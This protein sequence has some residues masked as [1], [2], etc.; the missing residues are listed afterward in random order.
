MW[1]TQMMRRWMPCWAK[2]H[3]TSLTSWRMRT[4]LKPLPR[5]H[6][7]GKAR[8]S[9]RSSQEGRSDGGSPNSLQFK[10]SGDISFDQKA[11]DQRKAAVSFIKGVTQCT[12]CGQCGH[13]TGG[14]ECSKTPKDKGHGKNQ[15]GLP[16]RLARSLIPRSH[17]ETTLSSMRSLNPMTKR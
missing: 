16:R 5:L 7:T 10:A 11:K 6:S 17:R 4:L 8:V 13:W 9:R 12:A 2:C 1:P 15:K 3:L 14:P